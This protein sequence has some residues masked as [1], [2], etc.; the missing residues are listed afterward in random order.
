MSILHIGN[1]RPAVGRHLLRD[2]QSG[3]SD[4]LRTEPLLLEGFSSDLVGNAWNLPGRPLTMAGRVE[5][6]RG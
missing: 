6:S 1:L 2:T 5:L 3:Y 4:R